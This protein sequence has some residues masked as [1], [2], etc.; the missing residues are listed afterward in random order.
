MIRSTS[1]IIL[2][3]TYWSTAVCYTSTLYLVLH[4][5]PVHVDVVQVERSKVETSNSQHSI[6]DP[7]RVK[8]RVQC[9]VR[10]VEDTCSHHCGGCGADR[11]IPVL[12]HYL[13][14]YLRPI[15]ATPKVE[16]VFLERIGTLCGTTQILGVD[17][18][19]QN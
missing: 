9:R 12:S 11:A 7:D 5:Y 14:V 18:F 2:A 6:R 19:D 8:S 13:V 4:A 1:T 10:L 15:D 17:H 3:M 16:R